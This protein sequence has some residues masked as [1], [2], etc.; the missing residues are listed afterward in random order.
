MQDCLEQESCE[1]DENNGRRG[2]WALAVACIALAV[3]VQI[4]LFSVG[5]LTQSPLAAS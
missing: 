3:K 5:K 4:S 2:V 1:Q